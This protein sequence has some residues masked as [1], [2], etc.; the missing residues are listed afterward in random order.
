MNGFMH[1]LET[2]NNLSGNL[3]VSVRC[4][5]PNGADFGALVSA[6]DGG[7]LGALYDGEAEEAV[8][9]G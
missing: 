3:L 8:L 4:S 6:I 2:M 5:P 7:H 9:V 1:T